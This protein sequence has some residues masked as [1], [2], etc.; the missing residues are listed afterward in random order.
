MAP[1]AFLGP[2]T[3]CSAD[4]LTHLKMSCCRCV[5]ATPGLML[6][7]D[8]DCCLVQSPCCDRAALICFCIPALMRALGNPYIR[9]LR[10]G[11]QAVAKVAPRS[12]TIDGST[13]GSA[14][15]LLGAVMKD[16]VTGDH[17][18]EGGALAMA[19][20]G[21]CC[22]QHLEKLTASH[23]VSCAH[24]LLIPCSCSGCQLMRGCRA[25]STDWCER[26]C[27]EPCQGNAAH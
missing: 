22:I 17:V 27:S 11:V 23:T 2:S 3:S 20:H 15:R 7:T 18:A 19:N 25:S 12:Q 1:L 21:L 24:P 14:G 13:P 5:A 16:V 6:K 4:R 8:A 10:A 26:H 9:L